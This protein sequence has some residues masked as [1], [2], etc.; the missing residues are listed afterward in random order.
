MKVC[1][2]CNKE[3]DDEFM[4]C[5]YCGS[6]L[7]GNVENVFC[8]YCGQL[9]DYDSDFCSFCGKRIGNNADLSK[10]CVGNQEPF[11]IVKDSEE[12]FFSKHHLF[13]YDGRRGRSSYFNVMLF[14]RFVLLI[15]DKFLDV[16]SD[17]VDSIGSFILFF[18]LLLVLSYPLFCN[19]AKRL[20]DLNVSTK[21][22]ICFSIIVQ[23]LFMILEITKASGNKSASVIIALILTAMTLPLL[24]IKGTDGSNQYGE[25]P[26]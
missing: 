24:I 17:K 13:S 22:A 3:Y 8:S 5:N 9:V 7:Q 25:D 23:I 2:K 20:H 11:Y 1:P 15:P 18:G 4:F 12:P 10:E 21:G 6:K 19:V 16:I 26:L 14:W